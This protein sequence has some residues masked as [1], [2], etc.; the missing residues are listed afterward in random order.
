[1]LKK[2][3]RTDNDLAALILRLALGIV[4]FPHGAQKALGWFGG[5]GL[6]A[7]LTAFTDKMHLPFVL[8]LLVVAA[9]FLGAIALIIGFCTRLA[10]LSIAVVMAAAIYMVHA[11]FG[12][13]MNWSGTQK[14]EGI[15]YHLLALGIAI[16]LT[17]KGGGAFSLDRKIAGR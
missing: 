9:E 11:Q 10:A 6:G 4:F 8:A 5:Y 12:F 14:G 7:T 15:E 2:M 16:A 17:I 1:M 13:F 3:M